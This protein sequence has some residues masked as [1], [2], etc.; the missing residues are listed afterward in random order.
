LHH[1]EI[2]EERGNAGFRQFARI[3]ALEDALEGAGKSEA[4]KN[5]TSQ[6]GTLLSNSAIVLLTLIVVT[7]VVA[8]VVAVLGGRFKIV[9]HNGRFH[10]EGDASQARL[11]EKDADAKRGK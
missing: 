1:H 4:G 2:F 3:L 9:W 7:G 5:V 6:E 8:V 11:E 10:M